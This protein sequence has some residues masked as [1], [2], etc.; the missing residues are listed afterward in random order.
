MA[1][2]A[3][4]KCPKS[5]PGTA[6]SFVP[7]GTWLWIECLPSHK[8]LG[9]CHHV[10]LRR[11]NT[12]PPQFRQGWPIRPRPGHALAVGLLPRSLRPARPCG[13]PPLPHARRI[14][15]RLT[16]AQPFMAGFAFRKRPKSRQG[17]QNLFVSR[18]SFVPAGTSLNG[19]DDDP[20]INGWAIVR[21]SR[22]VNRVCARFN[23]GR[24]GQ[25]GPGPALRWPLAFCPGPCG[26]F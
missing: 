22:H 16:I 2:F 7:A 3:F 15:M 9:Y 24:A 4:R 5:R 8:W 17:R 20:A 26:R 19:L 21:G 12:R 18:L 1:G 13:Q 23:S 11:S 25:S 10:A 14:E 6:A